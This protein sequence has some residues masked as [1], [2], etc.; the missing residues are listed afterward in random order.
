MHL[1]LY[2][3]LVLL[4]FKIL[5]RLL[6][7]W[8]EDM[9]LAGLDEENQSHWLNASAE[10]V[11]IALKD[12]SSPLFSL[13]TKENFNLF[14]STLESNI[15]HNTYFLDVAYKTDPLENNR[16]IHY[17]FIYTDLRVDTPFLYFLGLR[18][19]LNLLMRSRIV[20]L[21]FPNSA[22]V[23]TNNTPVFVTK[24]TSKSKKVSSLIS[25][26]K[27][28]VVYTKPAVVNPTPIQPVAKSKDFKSTL[29]RVING[30]TMYSQIKF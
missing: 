10:E 13:G 24:T 3:V 26:Y 23:S 14:K 28:N 19:S 4:V 5:D 30:Q 1:T 12:P 17:Q 27:P 7:V 8:N 6:D 2:I 9:Q 16:V 11:S 21:P 20:T 25:P 29:I 22:G 18:K 15:R